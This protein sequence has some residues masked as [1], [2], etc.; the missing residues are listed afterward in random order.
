MHKLI[1]TN[2]PLALAGLTVALLLSA[3][4]G[5]SDGI[6]PTVAAVDVTVSVPTEATTAAPA[7]TAYVSA[8]AATH[9]A[10]ADTLEPVAVPAAM[11]KDDNAEPV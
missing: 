2:L 7:A 9:S 5:G 4:G 11:A 1:L 3:C 6:K 8:L 10:Q